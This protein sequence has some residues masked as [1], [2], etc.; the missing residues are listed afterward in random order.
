VANPLAG[1]RPSEIVN[2]RHDHIILESNIPHIRVRPDE[3]VLNT[4]FSWR[5]IPLVGV[6][7]EAIRQFLDGFPR[8]RDN[9]DAFSAAAKTVHGRQIDELRHGEGF[10]RGH[11]SSVDGEYGS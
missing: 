3:R 1:A 8:Y 10:V 9:A 5:D 4:E 7:L 2:L 11:R 6:S